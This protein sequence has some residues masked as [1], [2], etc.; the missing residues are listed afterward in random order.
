VVKRSPALRPGPVT[1]PHLKSKSSILG[2]AVC[3]PSPVLLM[4]KSYG[5][6][7]LPPCHVHFLLD[8]CWP[9]VLSGGVWHGPGLILGSARSGSAWCYF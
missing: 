7:S 2:F 1:S 8:R 9:A 6:V 3:V 5:E 4:L